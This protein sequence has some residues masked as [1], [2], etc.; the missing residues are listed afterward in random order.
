MLV[1]VNET[2]NQRSRRKI[3]KIESIRPVSNNFGTNKFS[4]VYGSW[5]TVGRMVHKRAKIEPR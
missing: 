4:T 5:K 1:I 2:R 3:F